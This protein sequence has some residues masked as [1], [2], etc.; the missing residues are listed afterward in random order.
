MA[1]RPYKEGRWLIDITVGRRFRHREVFEGSYEEAVI[2]E[3]ELKKHLKTSKTIT[4]T[5]SDIAVEYLEHVRIHQSEKTFRDKRRI[6][7]KHILPFFGNFTFD[8]ITPR[9][10][11]AFKLKRIKELKDRGIQGYRELNLELMTLSNMSRWAVEFGYAS[12]SL[13]DIKKL[14]Y[15]RKLPQP[16]ELQTALKFFESAKEEP[17]YYALLLCLY[18][19][20]MRK[21]E[22]FHL[23]W[24][25]IL[26]QYNIIRVVKA[27]GGRERYIPLSNTLRNAL[28]GLYRGQSSQELV[29]PSPVTGGVL[30]DIRRAIRRIASRAGINQRIHPHQLRHT[31]ATHLL[32]R[33]I[34]IRAIQALLGH[35]DISTTQIYTKVALPMLQQAIKVLEANG[36]RQYVDNEQDGEF[37]KSLNLNEPWRIRT[38][39]PLIKSQLLYQ[40][41]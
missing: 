22:A 10:I 17:F 6:L 11:D 3:E 24:G 40:L 37:Y 18:H 21:N 2:Y 29:F 25:D 26:W 36:C 9:L 39:D 23:R 19:A 30:K 32:E 13:K 28:E 8:L 35:A 7:L 15:R 12:Q 31:F 33:G 14:P 38:S 1:V 27:K 20:G 5:V 34:D 41:S 4:K 16:L